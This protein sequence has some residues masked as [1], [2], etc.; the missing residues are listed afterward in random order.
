M[1]TSAASRRYLKRFVPTMLAY[2]AALFG[3]NYAIASQ[4]PTG[5]L[6]VALAILPALPIV[7]VIAVIGLYLVEET[8]EY[9]RQSAVTSMLAGLAIMLSA[10]TV[11]GFLEEAGVAPHLPAYW[12]FVIWCAAW[13]LVQ[14]VQNLRERAGGG[15]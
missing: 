7:G 11:W 12:A 6:L 5:A 10:A 3:A 15:A 1:H 4:H 2:V 13:G 9:V 8:D 14:C